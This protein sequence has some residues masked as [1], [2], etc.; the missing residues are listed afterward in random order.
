MRDLIAATGVLVVAQALA[1]HEIGNGIY[2]SSRDPSARL[3]HTQDG[4][5]LR[6]GA[7]KSLEIQSGEICS[8]TNENTRFCLS[9][10]IP[11]DADLG[12]SKYILV[13]AGVAYAQGGSGSS[14]RESSSLCFYVSGAKQ[15]ERIS[16]HF[17]IPLA[18]RRHPHHNLLVSFTP[19][20]PEFAVGGE[21]SAALRIENVGTN[22]VSFMKGG[23][24]RAARDNQYVFSARRNGKQVEDTGTSY[25]HGGL[26][27]ART[28]KPG[29]VF[30]DRID[31]TKWFAFADSGTY[32]IHG[33]Y[34]LAF[35]DPDVESFRTIWE[36]YVSADFNVI[37]K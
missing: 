34:Y 23:R 5:E 3:V 17:A 12:P 35:I 30:E 18:H 21:V 2:E 26:A 7:A 20:K 33:S 11:Y 28:L 27:A 10:T 13:V 16:K 32:E 14:E 15:A 25:H 36:D 4:R 31:L 19:S 9:L 6:C 1:A 8:Q 37:V 24:N 22:T 29:E